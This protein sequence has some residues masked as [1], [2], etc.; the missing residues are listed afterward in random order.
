M[1]GKAAT[2]GFTVATSAPILNGCAKTGRVPSAP[3]TRS[4]AGP[5]RSRA[6]WNLPSLTTTSSHKAAPAY[7]MASVALIVRWPLD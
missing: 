5:G 1:K 3:L 7:A 6:R 4:K 2:L